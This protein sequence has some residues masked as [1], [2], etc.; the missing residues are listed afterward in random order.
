MTARRR[1]GRIRK[2]PSDRWQARYSLPNGREISAPETFTTKTAAERWLAGI[3]TDLARGQWVDPANGQST[4]EAYANTWLRGRPDLK[5]RTRELYDWLLGKYVLPQLGY[6]PLGKLSPPVVRA[7]HAE[8]VRTAAPTPTRQAYSLLRAMLNTAVS[9]EL[10]LRN[11][12]TVRGAGVSRS[13]ERTVATVAQVNALAEAM[14]P[15]YRMLVLLAAWSGARWG[16]LVALSRDSL[17]LE[18]GTLTINRQYVELRDGSL[19]LDT[20]KT[21]AGVR[22]V[23]IPP[24]LMPE[25]Q[26]HL[27]TWTTPSSSVIFPNS[28]E[29][30]IRRASWRS[31]WLLARDKAELPQFRFHDLRHTGNTLAAATGAS[32]KELMARMGHASMRAALIYQHATADRDAAI[33]AALSSLAAGDLGAS[34]EAKRDGAQPGPERAPLS[35]RGRARAGATGTRRA[36]GQPSSIAN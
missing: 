7:W 6:V 9:D 21:A 1:F 24:H 28:K 32:T 26:Q 33:A 10:L 2:L 5:V 3:E 20:P 35:A 12:C 13:G 34:V 16:E 15:R 27:A 22:T 31:V 25:L 30:P 36:R 14:P 11:P 18:R 17:D 23:H 8:L 29:Q 19:V 4:L